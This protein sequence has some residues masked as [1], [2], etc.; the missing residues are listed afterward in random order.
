MEKEKFKYWPYILLA[1]IILILAGFAPYLFSKLAWGIEF[2]ADTGPIGDTIGGT[3]APFLSLVGSILVFAALR[4]QIHANEI[5]L[6]QFKREDLEKIEDIKNKMEI[7][8]LDL[9][10]IIENIEQRSERI[11]LF[12]DAEINSPFG[13][14]VLLRSITNSYYRILEID[15]E[16]VYKGF[17]LYLSKN[18]DW[19]KNYHKM[20]SQLDFLPPFFDDLYSKYE[21]HSVDIFNQKVEVG[22]K[23]DEIMSIAAHNLKDYETIFSHVEIKRLKQLPF[24]TITNS[25][26]LDWYKYLEENKGGRTNTDLIDAEKV[27]FEKFIEDA[28]SFIKEENESKLMNLIDEVRKLRMDIHSI[29]FRCNEFGTNLLDVHKKLVVDEGERKSNISELKE[30]KRIIEEGIKN[31]KI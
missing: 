8:C 18:D 14:N 31:N 6:K 13:F 9:E 28:V 22:K 4:A 29:A 21:K 7:L 15:R 26:I 5:V 2:G 3:T 19:I 12:A 25:L 20:Y 11:K 23:I 10:F 27:V 1:G 24:Y 17:K 30:I 16:S